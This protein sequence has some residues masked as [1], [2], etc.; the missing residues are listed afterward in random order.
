M[1]TLTSI[2]CSQIAY[3][4]SETGPT[5]IFRDDALLRVCKLDVSKMGTL[6]TKPCSQIASTRFETD[7]TPFFRDDTFLHDCI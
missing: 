4:R 1:G 6:A 7:P 5:P 3:A 2:P